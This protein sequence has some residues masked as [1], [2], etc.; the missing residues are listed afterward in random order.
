MARQ[1]AR[2]LVLFDFDGTIVRLETDYEQ[3]R[4]RLEE[5]GA[6]GEGLLELMS[7]VDDDPRAQQIVAEAELAGL[8]QGAEIEVGLGLYRRY[9][10]SGAEVAIVT[11]NSRDVVEEFFRNRDLPTPAEIF[12]RRAL[13][14]VKADSP[15]LPEY[16]HGA[17][18]VI[19]VG[20]S[21]FDRELARKLGG[22]FVDVGD[23]LSAYYEG[24]ARELD[25]LGVTYE[26][27]QPYKRFFYGARFHAVMRALDPRPG[28]EI[29]EVGCGSGYYTRELVRRGAAVTATEYTPSALA[30][31]RRNVGELA[32]FRLEDAQSLGFGDESFD[33][34]LLSEVIEHVPVPERAVAEASRV[35]RPGGLLVVSTPS[36]FSPLNL[37][38]GLKRRIR[39]YAFN[40][41]LHEF[42][43]GSF[44]RLLERDLDV[45]SLEYANF[46]LAY[47][48]DELYLWLGSPGLGLLERLERGLA[49]AP[50]LRRLGWTMIARARK[51]AT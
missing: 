51:P 5:L 18:S 36:R 46:V 16:A 23:E 31:A 38:Y 41:H 6:T 37:A 2:E 28:E 8:A 27:P 13:G 44:R 47:P 49:R 14:A 45:E 20:D 24:R 34:V 39:R 25:E 11:H 22:A 29:L 35:L 30:Q 12:D 48:A 7:A 50:V 43:P 21:D 26:H 17:E 10:S 4:S 32:E 15:A 19:V 42:T 1:T 9:A 3:L 33:K 40:E